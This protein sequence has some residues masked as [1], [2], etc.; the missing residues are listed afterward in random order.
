VADLQAAAHTLG[1]EVRI[2]YAD[3]EQQL[4]AVFASVVEER[5]GALVVMDDPLF[6]NNGGGRRRS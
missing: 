2:L 3:S 4:D 5:I 6:V 1:R